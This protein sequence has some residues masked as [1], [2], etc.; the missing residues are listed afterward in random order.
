MRKF[1][2]R[3]RGKI[4]GVMTEAASVSAWKSEAEM[5]IFVFMDPIGI[6]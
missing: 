5:R 4:I 6:I 1:C 3:R 2:V